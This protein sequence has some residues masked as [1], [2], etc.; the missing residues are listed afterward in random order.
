MKRIALTR[1]FPQPTVDEIV[2]GSMS[3]RKHEGRDAMYK[4]ST[5]LIEHSWL[6]PEEVSDA[7]SVLL[8]TWNQAFYRYEGPSSERLRRFLANHQTRLERLRSASILEFDEK[9]DGKMIRKLFDAAL[10]GTRTSRARTPVGTAKTLHLLAPG[11]FPLW[12]IEIA[13]RCG[14]YWN[15]SGEAGVKYVDFMKSTRTLLVQLTEEGNPSS[16]AR[17]GGAAR[18]IAQCEANGRTVTLLKLLDEYFYA[19]FTKGWV[20]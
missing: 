7:L 2:A 16:S 19:K 20:K 4:V 6:E 1:T 18:L 13:K 8:L 9:R 17:D 15:D 5:F 12:D 11:L 10:A 14:V 3:F